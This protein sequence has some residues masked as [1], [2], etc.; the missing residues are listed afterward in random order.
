MSFDYKLLGRKLQ[1]ARE[2]LLIQPEEAA[3]RLE[4]DPEEYL[5]IE[6]GERQA[7]GDEIVILASFFR[8]DFRYFVTGD[9]PSAESQ[10]Q[11]MFRQNATLTRGDRL[12]IQE[13]ARLCEYEAFLESV[14][15]IEHGTIPDYSHHPFGHMHY[16]TQGAEAAVLE[17]D[18]LMLGRQP[19]K[20]LFK[21]IRGQGIKVFKRQLE[22][23]NISGLYL[24]HPV[25]GHCILINYSDDL[26]R[27]NFSVAHEYCHALFDS[28]RKQQVSY[29]KEASGM[30]ELEWRANSFAGNFLV[31]EE[32]L[33]QDYHPVADYAAW[34]ELILRVARRFS[35]S[36]QVVVIRFA[37]MG[38]IEGALKNR[39]RNDSRLVIRAKG[40]F[41]PEIPP[42]LPPGT[43]ERLTKAIRNGLSWHF[44]QLCAEAYRRGEVTY[45]RV[46]EMLFLPIDEGTALLDEIPMYVEVAEP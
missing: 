3:E 15:E 4:I 16:K 33:R 41:D 17:R 45:H 43:K 7:T 1:E 27:Q 20:D 32:R 31:P 37:E 6:S 40:K 46:L 39:L 35:V 22:D 42:E 34:V 11:E 18:R 13:F 8:R 44:L 36:S 14:L 38:W 21:L 26:Y 23:R 5:R 29:V 28:A 24:R 12:A 10:I 2:S 19:I 9:Y 25:A 30:R